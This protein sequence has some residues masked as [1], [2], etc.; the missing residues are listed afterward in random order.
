MSVWI[1]HWYL[2]L[3][4]SFKLDDRF[5]YKKL[6]DF[7]RDLHHTFQRLLLEH[8]SD[9]TKVTIKHPSLQNP[10]VVPP[11][12]DLDP[13]KILDTIEKTLTSYE[14]LDADE[15]MTIVIGSIR[16][17]SGEGRTRVTNLARDLHTKK[18][19]VVVQNNDSLCALRAVAVAYCKL[20]LTSKEEFDEATKD[21]PG[22]GVEKVFKTGKCS[23]TFY[24]DVRKSDSQCREQAKMA[25]RLA[26]AADLPVDRPLTIADL[27]PLEDVLGVNVAVVSAD[28]G[29]RFVR[30]PSRRDRRTLYLYHHD[31]HYDA[32]VSITGFFCYPYFCEDCLRPYTTRSQHQ[33]SSCCTSC[34][35]NQCTVID[36]IQCPDCNVICRS[37]ACLQ[38]HRLSGSTSHLSLCQTYYQCTFCH[39]K[40]KAKRRTLHTC[41]EYKCPSCTYYVQPGHLCYQRALQAQ[42]PDPPRFV[43]YDFET[44]Q[45]NVVECPDGYSCEPKTDCPDCTE[46]VF[47]AS[48]RTCRHCLSDT[49]GRQKHVPNLVVAHTV[50]P[51]CHE[52]NQDDDC[53]ECGSLCDGC[54]SPCALCPL[55]RRHI[56]HETRDFFVW[57]FS[58]RYKDFTCLAHNAKGFDAYLVL[59]YLVSQS[60]RPQ[61]ILFNGTK[62]MYME[63]GR[64]LNLRFLD[65]LNFFPMKLAA[66]PKA[67]GLET[68]RKGYFPHLANVPR[69]WNYVGPYLDPSFYGADQMSRS[70]RDE[71]LTWHASVQYET[72]DFQKELVAYCDS[73]VDVLKNACL[74]YRDLMLQTVHVDPFSCLTVASVTNKVFKTKFLTET[75]EVT[76]YD[77]QKALAKLKDGK[78]MYPDGWTENDVVSKSFISSPVAAVPPQGYVTGRQFSKNSIA[79]LEWTA[80]QRG[81]RIRHALNDLG[82]KKFG[83]YWVDGYDAD[84]DEAFEYHGCFWHGCPVC[85]PDDRTRTKN[86][87][88][89]Q[90]MSELHFWTEKKMSYLRACGLKVTVMWEHEFLDQ[91]KN[92][93]NLRDF[94][95]AQDL[96]DRL[97]PRDAFFGGR[98]NALKLYEKVE[99]PPQ[100]RYYDVT[101][102]YPYVRKTRVFPEGHPKIVKISSLWT[103]TL[104]WPR[105][106]SCRLGDCTCQCYHTK[107][108]IAFF[109]L[110]ATLAPTRKTWDSAP[111]RTNREP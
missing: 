77:G 22:D 12:K 87:V 28:T 56:F 65:S 17:P 51:S 10:I 73:D 96:T 43:F 99:A 90:S 92:D 16:L 89:G 47:C 105:S 26:L 58:K 45:H 24:R 19:V 36:E 6:K 14:Q 78:W 46:N 54:S 80:R 110:C 85:Y 30:K 103:G 57:L 101:S 18:S 83:P 29:N 13:Q 44:T 33:C 94:A 66:L 15:Q 55:R 38:R 23:P 71:F 111:V 35:S 48:C 3:L 7:Y 61:R 4:F 70:E 41:G 100:I 2:I 52:D 59:D 9:L 1:Q 63:V 97:N 8:S 84:N 104:A 95:A 31:D 102:L 69:Y 109:S 79:W 62:L 39:K 91:W 25:R 74:K 82:E 21:V 34:E 67:F 107:L 98:T 60:I 50:C 75:W 40:M 106:R 68:C 76:N 32:I 42:S 81:I 11:Q 5:R 20:T 93:P 37:D 108:T 88:T 64:G 86:P 49:C 53:R 27:Q 72:F